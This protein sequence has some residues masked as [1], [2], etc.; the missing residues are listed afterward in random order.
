[1]QHLPKILGLSLALSSSALFAAEYDINTFMTIGA[2]SMAA[3]TDAKGEYLQAID[4]NISFEYDSKFGVNL[5]TQVTENI[6]GA[7]QLTANGRDGN[8]ELEAE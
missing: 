6:E 8:F 4:D 1:M 2:A 7:A 3:S 5:N